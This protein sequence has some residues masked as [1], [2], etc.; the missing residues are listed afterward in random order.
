MKLGEVDV[1]GRPRPEPIAGSE[2]E[3]KADAVIVAVGERADIPG[4]FGLKRT[5]G[6]AIWVNSE[7]LATSKKGV[8][9]GGD[10]VSGPASIIESIAAGRKAAM[11]IDKYLGGKGEIDEVLA[12]PEGEV[13]PLDADELPEERRV[14]QAVAMSLA[15]RL[16]SFNMPECGYME[17][18]AVKEAKRCLRC[19]ANWLYTVNE[20]KCKGCYNCKVICPVVG[21]INMKTVD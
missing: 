16:F 20:D 10:V 13:E 12:L 15:K 6:N 11:S 3:I 1:S 2:F 14:P 4:Q 7:T 18:E 5:E 17:E 19:D 9:A 8:F 21:C